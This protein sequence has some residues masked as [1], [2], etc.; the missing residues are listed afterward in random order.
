MTD[1]Y[2][3]VNEIHKIFGWREV[4]A[5]SKRSLNNKP[6]L[7]FGDLL[8]EFLKLIPVDQFINLT[9]ELF[10]ENDPALLCFYAKMRQTEMATLWKEL[11]QFPPVVRL[12][13]LLREKGVEIDA[14]IIIIES[15]FNWN[16]ESHAS[17]LYK[18][19]LQPA[20][21]KIIDVIRMD[22]LKE[23][24]QEVQHT[25]CGKQIL[26]Y[27]RGPQFDKL[28][29]DFYAEKGFRTV[30]FLNFTLTVQHDIK[31]LLKPSMYLVL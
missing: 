21:Q 9:L 16:R 7:S 19:N 30:I 6:P 4:S 31:L 20:F 14:L 17:R 23:Y 28:I 13:E 1:I 11:K 12:I 18:F 27:L 22:K 29:K 15:L 5:Y 10:V 26:S 24:L 8:E 3:K 25:N 2:N